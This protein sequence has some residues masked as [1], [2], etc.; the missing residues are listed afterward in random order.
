M[1]NQNEIIAQL[2]NVVAQNPDLVKGFTSNPE[3]T[4][5]KTAEHGGIDLSNVNMNDLLEAVTPLVKGDKLDVS[6]VA[7][8][9]GELFGGSSSSSESSSDEGIANILGALGNVFGEGTDHED[10]KNENGGI[11]LSA[12][13]GIASALFG[14]K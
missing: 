6:A 5:K 14:G 13:G 7:K 4:V 12:L 2:I 8:V 10:K 3:E 9:A 11:D 1:A